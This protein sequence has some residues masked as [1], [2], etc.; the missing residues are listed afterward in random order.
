MARSQAIWTKT[1]SF[2]IRWLSKKK[3]SVRGS[4]DFM[5]FYSGMKENDRRKRHIDEALDL[6]KSNPC[7]GDKIEKRLWPKKYVKEHCIYNLF[8]YHLPEG[9][10]LTYTIASE[11]SDEIVCMILEVLSHPEYENRFGYKTS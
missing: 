8:R 7:S 10:R 11:S 9:Y 1:S 4:K 3:I 5:K 6:L 2:S